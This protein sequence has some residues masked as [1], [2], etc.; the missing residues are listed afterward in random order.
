MPVGVAVSFIGGEGVS[1][2]CPYIFNAVRGDQLCEIGSVG[3][4]FSGRILS[5]S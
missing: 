1:S 2:G 3:A 5:I 4:V